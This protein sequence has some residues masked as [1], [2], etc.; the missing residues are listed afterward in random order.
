M[1]DE[2]RTVSKH[3]TLEQLYRLGLNKKKTTL[4]EVYQGTRFDQ[5]IPFPA[6]SLDAKLKRQ[7]EVLFKERVLSNASEIIPNDA[8]SMPKWIFLEYLVKYQNALLHGSANPILRFEPRSSQDNIVDGH[9]PRVYA[10]SSGI[11]ATFFAILDRPFLTKRG[12]CAMNVFYAPFQDATGETRE[13][14][15]FAVDYRCLPMKPYQKGIVHV[16]SRDSFTSDSRGMQWYSEIPVVPQAMIEMSPEDFPLLQDIRGI[17]WEFL[18][19][20][21]PDTME[22]FPWIND[23][24]LY[25]RNKNRDG[26]NTDDSEKSRVFQKT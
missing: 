17:D 6:F 10:A 15:H 4:E 3:L 14:F 19:K 26:E 7:C 20:N 24:S 16:L 18:A 5:L 22:G 9:L 2:E 25:P 12:I 11:M 23:E 1:S 21:F 8:F 13:G